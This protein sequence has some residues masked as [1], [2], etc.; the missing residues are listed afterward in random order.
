MDRASYEKK[1]I[2]KLLAALDPM[3]KASP[4]FPTSLCQCQEGTAH[5]NTPHTIA[6]LCRMV[7]NQ[8]RHKRHP[9]VYPLRSGV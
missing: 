4:V 7:S 2:L 3:R 6:L 8:T 5:Y 9:Q 1:Y